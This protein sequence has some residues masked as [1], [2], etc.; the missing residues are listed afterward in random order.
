MADPPAS[1]FKRGLVRNSGRKPDL[2]GVEGADAIHVGGDIRSEPE[3]FTEP[4]GPA[5][6]V[7]VTERD[8]TCAARA[9]R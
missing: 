4:A 6:A 2:S 3:E 9:M 1:L 5:R 8:E 7:D